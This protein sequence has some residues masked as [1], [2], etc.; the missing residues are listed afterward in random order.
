MALNIK[1]PA[2]T[3]RIRELSKAT[4]ENMTQAVRV[5]VEERLERIGRRRAGRSLVERLDEIARHCSSLPVR[6]RRSEDE[7]LGYDERG[8]PQ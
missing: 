4:V 1:D 5:A 7:I 3:A 2:T 6:S 8:L